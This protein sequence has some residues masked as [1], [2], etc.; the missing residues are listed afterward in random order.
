M[1]RLVGGADG[2]R[3]E[4]LERWAEEVERLFWK[5]QIPGVAFE[6]SESRSDLLEMWSDP[7]VF[8]DA[9]HGL[10]IQASEACSLLRCVIPAQTCPA[11]EGH[12]KEYESCGPDSRWVKCGTCSA[13]GLI[14]EPPAIEATWL[15]FS[16]CDLVRVIRGE[17]VRRLIDGYNLRVMRDMFSFSATDRPL[18]QI[19]ERIDLKIDLEFEK[20]FPFRTKSQRDFFPG[21]RVTGITSTEIVNATMDAGSVESIPPDLRPE[22]FAMLHDALMDAGCDDE[23]ILSHLP[24]PVH[25]GECFVIKSLTEAMR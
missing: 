25:C 17:P 11:C 16:V 18:P 15:T 3:R 20:N 1:V 7:V 23:A 21:L 22:L 24:E 6:P 12:K 5:R 9:G 14:F 10:V 2:P 13:T 4:G 8:N 19:G